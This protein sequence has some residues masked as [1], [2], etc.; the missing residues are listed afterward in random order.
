MLATESREPADPKTMSRSADIFKYPPSFP[1]VPVKPTSRRMSRS[2]CA[3]NCPPSVK[4]MDEARMISPKTPRPTSDRCRNVTLLQPVV[5]PIMLTSAGLTVSALRSISQV[6]L[7]PYTPLTLPTRKT[8][9]FP[10]N[11]RTPSFR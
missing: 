10:E 11:V 6:P 3:T 8:I 5:A 1:P 4:L 7:P 2:A 9:G